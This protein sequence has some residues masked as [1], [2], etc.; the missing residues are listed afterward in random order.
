MV[1]IERRSGGLWAVGRCVNP[2]HRPS[3]EPRPRGLRLRRARAPGRAR[4]R[5]HDAGGR[6]PRLRAGRT[7][8]ARPPVRARGAAQAPRALVLRPPLRLAALRAEVID[9]LRRLEAAGLVTGTS[10]NVSARD[11]ETGLIAVS[12]T[13]IPYDRMRPEDVSVVDPEGELLEGASAERRVADAPGHPVRAPGSRGGSSTPTR[14]MRPPSGSCWTRSRSCSP[15]RRRRSAGRSLSRRTRRPA[16][17]R[18]ARPCWRAGD[19]WAAIVR[20][21]GPVCLGRSLGEALRCAFAVE[22]AAEVYAIARQHGEPALLPE[23]ELVR[24]NRL[25]LRPRASAERPARSR[26]SRS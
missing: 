19:A 25:R 14:R 17:A 20:S 21:H 23:D 16:S 15:S 8:R 5:E 13:S 22:E 3:D 24:L 7:A 4:G 2:Q 6:R 9:V 10:G 11:P 18:W 1:W 26:R 12:P